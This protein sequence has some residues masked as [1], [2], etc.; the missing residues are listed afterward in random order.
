V[1]TRLSSVLAV[2]NKGATPKPVAEPK[3]KPEENPGVKAKTPEPAKAPA[4]TKPADPAKPAA[5][6]VPAS[7]PAAKPADPEPPAPA[8]AKPAKTKKEPDVEGAVERGFDR[9]ADK[10]KQQPAQPAPKPAESESALTAKDKSKLAVFKEMAKSNP[11]LATLPGQFEAFVKAEKDYVAK[12]TAENPGKKFDP[13]ADD[14]SEFYDEHEPQYD[15][16]EYVE[17]KASMIARDTV[18]SRLKA[19]REKS[20]QAARTA[21][22][23]QR[24]VA[25]AKES[26]DELA[27]AVAGEGITLKKLEAEDPFAFREVKRASEEMATIAKEA[28]RLFSPDSTTPLDPKNPVHGVLFNRLLAYEGEI[29][30]LEPEDRVKAGPNGRPLQFATLADFQE[31]S[32]AQ[33]AK[34]WTLAMEPVAMKSLLVRDLA[35]EVNKEISAAEKA[36]EARLGKKSVQKPPVSPATTAAKPADTKPPSITAGDRIVTP[37]PPA[38]ATAEDRLA[39]VARAGMRG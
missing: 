24:G 36:A 34:H 16:D 19:D 8:P 7:D 18:D 15:P 38:A 10:L 26:A 35:A 1:A 17:A 3:M 28:V 25:L 39:W 27:A 13:T 4:D 32:A 6:T 23:E 11:E 33:Q 30:R 14:H 22:I 37:I 9:I 21:S 20:E 31:M 5:E 12:W 2:M 29:Q